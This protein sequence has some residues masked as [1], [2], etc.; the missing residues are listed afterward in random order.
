MR[1]C[2]INEQKN[3]NTFGSY[4]ILFTVPYCTKLAIVKRIIGFLISSQN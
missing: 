2:V 1:K 3:E 4:R